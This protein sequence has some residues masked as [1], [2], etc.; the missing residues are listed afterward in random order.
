MWGLIKSH[1]RAVLWAA[2]V[3]IVFIVTMGISFHFIDAPS[4]T[5]PQQKIVKAVLKDDS[6]EQKKLKKKLEQEKRRKK[7]I[8]QKKLK[9]EKLKEKKRQAE[10]KKKK[11]AKIAAQKKREKEQAEKRRIE[12]EHQKQL[13]QERQRIEQEK[14]EQKRREDALKKELE[15]EQ[16]R[17]AAEREARNETIISKQITIIKGHIEQRWIK[18]AS[19]K[20]GMVCVIRVSLIPSGEVINVRYIKRSGNSAFDQSVFTAVKRASPLP[21]PPVEYGLSD[22]F[23]EIDLNFGK[24]K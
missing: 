12:E 17:L 19:T 3:H 1:P 16:Q 24:P 13:E 6:I 11:L 15:E 22:R 21:L 8:E 23:R 9:A 5:A 18:P 4:S 7:L 2:I 14:A 10:L 20:A